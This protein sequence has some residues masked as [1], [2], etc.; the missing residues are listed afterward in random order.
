MVARD[1]S[2]FAD[3]DLTR[4]FLPFDQRTAM[5]S[6]DEIRH[7]LRG[8]GKETEADE[9][10]CKACGYATCREHAIAIYRGLAETQMCLPYVIDRFDHTV[11]QLSDSNRQLETTQEQLMH[12]ERLASM[13][14]LAA[15]VAHELNNP[16]GVVLLYAHLLRDEAGEE[17]RHAQGADPHQRPGHALQAHRLGPARLRA[18]EQAAPRADQRRRADQA[19]PG[20]PA[21]AA[22]GE[23][24]HRPSVTRIPTARSIRRR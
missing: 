8:M 10:D 5:P 3:L 21:V 11:R 2:R 17:L 19:Q 15:G 16:L 12:S 7:I 14:Q 6:E 23:H 24:R 13:G 1:G 18:R 9:L 4:T 22:H 20:R